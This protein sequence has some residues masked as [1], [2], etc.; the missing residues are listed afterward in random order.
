MHEVKAH[1][2]IIIEQDQELEVLRKQLRARVELH[3]LLQR[4]TQVAS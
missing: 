1:K 4:G 2:S 3:I